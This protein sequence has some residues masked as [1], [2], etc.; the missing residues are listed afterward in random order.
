MVGAGLEFDLS[1]STSILLDVFYN[2]G[3][4]KIDGSGVNDDTKNRA[5]YILVGASIPV[6]G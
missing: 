1:G 4:T 5:F 6:G 2:L 3:L